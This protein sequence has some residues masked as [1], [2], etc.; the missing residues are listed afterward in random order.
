[1]IHVEE[2]Q[3]IVVLINYYCIGHMSTV[4]RTIYWYNELITFYRTMVIV[5][6]IPGILSA[7]FTPLYGP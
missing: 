6:R 2:D 5:I 7:A 1:M 3:L 4:R